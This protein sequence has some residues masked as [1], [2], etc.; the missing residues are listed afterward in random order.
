MR[1]REI[2]GPDQATT[3]QPDV[4]SGRMQDPPGAWS[5]GPTNVTS[6]G[7]S[8]SSRWPSTAKWFVNASMNAIDQ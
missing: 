3:E 1:I 6:T 4:V 5:P 8:P 7:P 2:L